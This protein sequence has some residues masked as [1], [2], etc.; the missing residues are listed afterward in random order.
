MKKLPSKLKIG[1][2]TY[3]IVSSMTSDSLA[4]QTDRIRHEIL[5]HKNLEPTEKVSTLLH[6]VLHVCNSTMSAT[7]YGHALVD[8]LAEQIASVLINNKLLK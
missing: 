6:E 4:G 7:E 1:A 3:K 2:H 5:I 8:S